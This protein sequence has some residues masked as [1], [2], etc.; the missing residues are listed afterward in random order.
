M[1]L[2][3]YRPIASSRGIRNCERPCRT[4]GAGLELRETGRVS[5]GCKHTRRR[6]RFDNMRVI[7]FAEMNVA[8]EHCRSHFSGNWRIFSRVR[9]HVR[10]Q[11]GYCE[12]SSNCLSL[13]RRQ[14]HLS[15]WRNGIRLQGTSRQSR[16]SR[17]S[18][19]NSI[20]FVPYEYLF[21]LCSFQHWGELHLGKSSRITWGK[22][23][24]YTSLLK[25]VMYHKFM[26]YFSGWTD[27]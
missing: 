7:L 2:H 9:T 17:F 10:W 15:R 23:V 8:V 22:A 14:A 13:Y 1:L 11:P 19:E 3:F 25:N 27:F 5:M 6:R 24:G 12:N 16:R 18:N 21:Y 26:A 20:N 4:E